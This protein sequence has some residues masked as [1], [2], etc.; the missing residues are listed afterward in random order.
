MLFCC[1]QFFIHSFI[2][3]FFFA[4]LY[5]NY[6]AAF[7]LLYTTECNTYIIQLSHLYYNAADIFTNS[8]IAPQS[9]IQLSTNQI[10]VKLVPSII[11]LA[12]KKKTGSSSF[13][14]FSRPFTVYV[15][16]SHNIFSYN[17]IIINIMTF[18][19]CITRCVF[20][21]CIMLCTSKNST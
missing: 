6:T 14:N 19:R 1:S 20:N 4:K 18:R 17:I 15:T 2:L 21:R 13:R 9:R 8:Y 7:L 11:K 3:T 12:K 10:K 5:Y 16:L